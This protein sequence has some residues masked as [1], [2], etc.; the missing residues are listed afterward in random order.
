M[1]IR[2][3][4]FLK[5]FAFVGL[6]CVPL[7]WSQSHADQTTTPAVVHLPHPSG[8]YGVA[9]MGYDWTDPTRMDTLANTPDV[10]REIMVYVWYPIEP[11]SEPGT[12]APYLPLADVFVRNLSKQ[13]LQNGWGSSWNS[14]FSN[15]VLS[16]A[17]ENVPVAAGKDRFPVIVFS[18]G[19]GVLS[20]QYTS[21]IEEIVSRGYVVAGIE[22]V[23]ETSAVAFPEGRVIRSTPGTP[24]DLEPGE[25]EEHY[26]ERGEAR[27]AGGINTRSADMRFVVDQLT[28]L[29]KAEKKT[30]PFAGRLDLRNIAALGHSLGGRAAVRAC[31]LDRRFKACLNADGIGP[32]GPIFFYNGHTLPV[33]PFMWIQ[34]TRPMIPD[35]LLK[36][37]NTTRESWMQKQ[38]ENFKRYELLQF[39]KCPGGSYYLK[40][41]VPEIRHMSFSDQPSI[42]A[43]NDAD[44]NQ[45]AQALTKIESYT[46]A[47]LDKYLKHESPAILRDPNLVFV[48]FTLQRYGKAR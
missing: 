48:G 26:K 13:E 36:A 25:S 34:A 23:Y 19:W 40:I 3:R 42:D 43:D 11:G 1:R 29:N 16:D 47:F 27:A 41:D 5:T 39:Q 18:S 9:R 38:Q 4:R 15:H 37:F 2:N 21:L 44:L 33:Q 10:H 8:K 20:T 31:Q 17:R 45:A 28:A 30:A 12:A 6:V 24:F 7:L 14:V 46:I 32:N 35:R 22:A